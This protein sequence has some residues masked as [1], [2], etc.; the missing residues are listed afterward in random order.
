MSF[1]PVKAKVRVISQSGVSVD[2]ILRNEQERSQWIGWVP[3]PTF[4][5]EED[6]RYAKKS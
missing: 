4:A 1:C 5:K 6:E 2:T 3:S